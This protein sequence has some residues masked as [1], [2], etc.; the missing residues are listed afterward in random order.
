MKNH[1]IAGLRGSS[2]N[3]L[4]LRINIVI[5]VALIVISAASAFVGSMLQRRSLLKGLEQQTAQLSEILAVNVAAPLSTLD[6]EKLNAFVLGFGKE[7][8]VR[9]VRIED[10]TGNVVAVF[11]DSQDSH[12]RIVARRFSRVGHKVVGSVVL[13]MATDG[14]DQLMN[15][16][17]KFVLGREAVLFLVLLSLLFYLLRWQVTQPVQEMNRLLQ[18]AHETDD[19]TLRLRHQR[20]DEIGEM[21]RWFNM[22]VEKIEK[23]VHAV[24][25]NAETLASSAEELTAVSHQM[26]SNAEETSAQTSVVA[27]ASQQVGKNVQT[28]STGTE[29]MN[30][31]IKEIA[32][33][34]SA[35]AR[36][37]SNAVALAQNTNSTVSKLGESSAEIGQVIKVIT[38]IAEQTNLLALNATIEAARAGEA[39]KGF[40]IVANEVKELAKQTGKATE[41]ISQRIKSIQ[42]NTEDAVKAIGKISEVINQISDISNSIASAVEEQSVTTAEIS[43]NI[44][45]AAQGAMDI[46]QTIAAVAHGAQS[47]A[48]GATETKAAAEELARMAAELESLVGQFKV[49]EDGAAGG[50][51]Q[52]QKMLPRSPRAARRTIQGDGKI[53]GPY[54]D[55]YV[56]R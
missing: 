51:I 28:V 49:G 21:S 16:N 37:A 46:S 40:S 23:L 41:D 17:W 15:E 47:T 44:T 4:T 25:Y 30:A 52:E 48:T 50:R 29:Q 32:M 7:P 42:A 20:E 35:A 31:S 24:A 26:S 53:K 8:S 38:S 34:A 54:R 5:G 9:F 45:E 22:F 33:N 14:V 39:G 55:T 36:V 18:G 43:R 2:G 19:L 3:R 11:G 13:G 1:S 10:T 12:G 6:Q 56:E 27:A